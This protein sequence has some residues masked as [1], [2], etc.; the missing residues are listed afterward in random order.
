MFTCMYQLHDRAYFCV[1]VCVCVCVRACVHAYV[2]ASVLVAFSV[3]LHVLDLK[4]RIKIVSSLNVLMNNVLYSV[5]T[6][7]S[8]I[9]N[10]QLRLR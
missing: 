8:F 7:Y 5:K 10:N 3:Y 2:R 1:C 9:V 4:W 6:V